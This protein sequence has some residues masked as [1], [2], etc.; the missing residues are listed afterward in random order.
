[1]KSQFVS[2]R[3]LVRASARFHDLVYI[4][5]KGKALLAQDIAHTSLI[6]VDE[7]EWASAFDTDWDSTAIA[8]ARLPSEKVVV[9]GEDGDVLTY[10]GGNSNFEKILPEPVMIRNANEI[11][12]FVYACGMKRQVYKRIDE[13][14]WID[15]SAPS[16]DSSEKAGFEAIG[17]YS[18]DEIYAVGWRGEI[19]GFDG[20]KWENK[21]SPTNKILTSICC[22][23]KGECYI[24]G[25]QGVVIK[26]RKDEWEIIN[27]ESDINIDFWDLCWFQD[28]LYIASMNNLYVLENNELID[29]DFGGIEPPSCFSLTTSEGILWSVGNSDVVSF[30]GTSWKS[31]E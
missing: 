23:P 19:W 18:A 21:A 4:I 26:G 3:E 27:R 22:T 15:L 20:K 5:S 2:A 30:D 14:K 6:A 24:C 13:E 12:G 17:G 29:V 28:R 16:P 9:I 25:Q 7:G 11:K 10:V 31:Y 1:M 8:V